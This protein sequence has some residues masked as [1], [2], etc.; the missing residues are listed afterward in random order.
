M[1]ANNSTER[2][3][4]KASIVEAMLTKAP[5]ATIADMNAT[6]GWQPHSCRAFLAGL[7]KKGKVIERT[8][9]KDG[10]SCYRIVR[11]RKAVAD[12]PAAAGS[13]QC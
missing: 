12:L 5:G 3:P 6:T 9:R 13:D 4:S 11:P 2:T 8:K 10:S 7:R 1:S